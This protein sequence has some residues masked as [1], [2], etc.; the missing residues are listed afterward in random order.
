MFKRIKKSPRNKFQILKK[1]ETI[2]SLYFGWRL[3]VILEKTTQKLRGPFRSHRQY[4]I[5][6]IALV[7]IVSGSL[8]LRNTYFSKAATYEWTQSV[9]TSQTANTAQHG[10]D[11]D[12]WEQYSAVD[13]SVSTGESVSIISETTALTHTTTS[14]FSSGTSVGTLTTGDQVSL[15]LP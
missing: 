6:T 12:N 5:A 15:D 3:R 4:I 9:W 1:K 13:S 14:D 2:F 7:F 8:V 10:V 11:N